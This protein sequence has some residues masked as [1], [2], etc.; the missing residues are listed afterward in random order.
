MTNLSDFQRRTIRGLVFNG[1]YVILTI[2][3]FRLFPSLDAGGGY[4]WILI[5]LPPLVISGILY[6]IFLHNT[7]LDK[8]LDAINK[9]YVDKIPKRVRSSKEKFIA[10]TVL[11]MTAA[12]AFGILVAVKG[13]QGELDASFIVHV[14]IPCIAVA[15]VIL[16]MLDLNVI[17]D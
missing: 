6:T 17:Y 15:T 10:F 13:D 9:Q 2:I 5:V 4:G 8:K 11:I 1:L 3:L 12:A 16:D 14:V 7:G